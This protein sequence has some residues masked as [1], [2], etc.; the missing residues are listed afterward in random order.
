MFDFH[1]HTHVSFDGSDAHHANRVG[2]YCR[3]AEG[4]VRDIFGYVC[5]FVHRKPQFHR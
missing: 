2:R 4:I 3:K 5:T 1:P